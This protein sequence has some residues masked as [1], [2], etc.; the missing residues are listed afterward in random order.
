MTT[1]PQAPVRAGYGQGFLVA[2]GLYGILGLAV[3][4]GDLSLPPVEPPPS[5]ACVSFGSCPS[6]SQGALM[7]AVVTAPVWLG[8]LVLTLV[9]LAFAVRLTRSGIVAGVMTAFA[10]LGAG[11][12][13]TLVYLGTRS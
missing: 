9:L 10:V 4:A 6:R 11:G 3:F 5:E 13:V 7:I 8:G 2:L 1:S 12:L